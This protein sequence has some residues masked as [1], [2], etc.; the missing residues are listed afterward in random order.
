MATTNKTNSSGV[1]TPSLPAH[2]F[3]QGVATQLETFRGGGNFLKLPKGQPRVATSR[4]S[5][6]RKRVKRVFECAR[7]V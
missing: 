6:E 7:P 1:A 5:I 3:S 2:S 4:E